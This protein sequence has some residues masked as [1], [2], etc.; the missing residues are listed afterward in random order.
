MNLALIRHLGFIGLALGTSVASWVNA[1]LLIR[2]LEKR[3]GKFVN[4]SF[5]ISLAKITVAGLIMGL[6]AWGIHV[7]ISGI[8]VTGTLI[9]KITAL[10][11][12]IAV[13]LG[14]LLLTSHLLRIEQASQMLRFVR[15][16]LNRQDTRT[17]RTD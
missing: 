15:R 1:F 9:L 13:A 12:S 7:W 11:V 16:K 6:A 10:T 5:Y 14:V 4:R 8:I 17:P 3:T 2:A